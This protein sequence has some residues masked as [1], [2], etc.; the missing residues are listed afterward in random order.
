MGLAGLELEQ[1][2]NLARLLEIGLNG[3]PEAAALV[4]LERTWSWSELEASATRLAS[5][6]LSLGLAPGDRVASLMPNRGELLVH[7]LACM[8]AGLAA[9]RTAASSGPGSA[10][11][12]GC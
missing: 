4:T 11:T 5:E 1:P 3:S 12:R 9:T 10:R 8:K 2:T 6:Y 7:Y